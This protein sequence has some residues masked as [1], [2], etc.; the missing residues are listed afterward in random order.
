MGPSG[1]EC[2]VRIPIGNRRPIVIGGFGL[3]EAG[4]GAA[5][6]EMAA[7]DFDIPSAYRHVLKARHLIGQFIR[8]KKPTRT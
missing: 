2:S 1:L 5:G 7:A 6:F 8:Q 4:V 3:N